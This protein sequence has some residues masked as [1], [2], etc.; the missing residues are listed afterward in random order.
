[1]QHSNIYHGSTSGTQQCA[2]KIPGLPRHLTNEQIGMVSGWRREVHLTLL[3][4]A[5]LQQLKVSAGGQLDSIMLVNGDC[6]LQAEQA[7]LHG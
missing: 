5:E 6:V 1:M 2:S 3:G 7:L 4:S